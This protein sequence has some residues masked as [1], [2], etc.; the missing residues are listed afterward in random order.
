MALSRISQRTRTL[1][2]P[3]PKEAI[4]LSYDPKTDRAPM[5][6]AKGRGRIAQAIVSRAQAHD[7]PVISDPVLLDALRLVEVGQEIP[8]RLYHLVAEL[9]AFVH[10]LAEK[11]AGSGSASPPSHAHHLTNRMMTSIN[12]SIASSSSE[13]WIARRTQPLV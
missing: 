10:N 7:V 5:V 9:L 11:S 4:A 3:R 12:S 8:P 1:E 2:R 13:V 6:V